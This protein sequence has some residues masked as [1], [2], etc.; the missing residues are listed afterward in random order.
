MEASYA[1]IVAS[2]LNVRLC[3]VFDEVEVFVIVDANGVE[4]VQASVFHRN[5]LIGATFIINE[6]DIKAMRDS[7]GYCKVVAEL[8]GR[9]IINLVMD[10]EL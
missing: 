5:A 7:E 2:H 3:R 9:K 1:Q 6:S 4:A 10:Q 8:A